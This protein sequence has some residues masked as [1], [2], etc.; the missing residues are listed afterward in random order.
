MRLKELL[1]H[2][3]GIYT[4]HA[5]VA[6]ILGPIYD[7]RIPSGRIMSP[8]SGRPFKLELWTKLEN[9]SI[10]AGAGAAGPGGSNEDYIAYATLVAAAGGAPLL[11]YKAS[12]TRYVQ[13][14]EVRIVY[15]GTGGGTATVGVVATLTA[16]SDVAIG[17]AIDAGDTYKQ[18]TDLVTVYYRPTVSG[19]FVLEYARPDMLGQDGRSILSIDTVTMMLNNPF[20]RDQF[21]PF[22]S[23]TV[24]P[25]QWLLRMKL[26]APWLV[27]FVD[28]LPTPDVA[29]PEWHIP[30]I[31]E[32][33][34]D[35]DPGVVQRVTDSLIRY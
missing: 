8:D 32:S 31:V 26:D 28:A 5:N 9:V 17:Y 33:M 30:L 29:L 2:R 16:N 19:L 21:I 35:H 4:E 3:E 34:N 15:E 14:E 18:G 1:T 6:N 23:P 11:P 20:H 10:S 25:E 7:V 24:W 12:G 22:R 27:C 13:N